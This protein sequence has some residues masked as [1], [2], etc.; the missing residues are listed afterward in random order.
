MHYFSPAGSFSTYMYI[1]VLLFLDVRRIYYAV[2]T[3]A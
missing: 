2:N 1:P 3:Q